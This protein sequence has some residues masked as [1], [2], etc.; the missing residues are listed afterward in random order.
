MQSIQSVVDVFFRNR[1]FPALLLLGFASGLPLFLTSR[2]L[3]IWMADAKVD[4][5]VIGWFSVVALPYSLK[6][7]WSPVMDRF[8]P[9]FL[10]R[11]RGWLLMTQVALILAI[12]VMAFQEPSSTNPQA[13]Q[14]L[15][16]TALAVTFFSASQDIAGDAYRTD[17]LEV[18]ERE[19]GASL[20]VLGYRLALLVTS[21]LALVLVDWFSALNIAAPWRWVYLLMAGLMGIGLVTTIWA[22]E[23]TDNTSQRPTAPLTLQDGLF[24]LLG[25]GVIAGIVELAILGF[26]LWIPWIVLGVLVLWVVVS[27]LMPQINLED[28][29]DRHLPQT[30]QEAVFQPFQ[31]FVQRRGVFSASM[32]LAFIVLYKLGDSLVG[33]MA[34]PFLVTLGFSKSSIGVI[35]GG[36]GFLATTSGVFLGGIILTQVGMNRALWIFGAL[37]LLSNFGYYALALA[38]KNEQLMVIAINIENLCAGFVTVVVVAYLMS[39]CDKRFTTT[40][41]A[42]FSSLMAISR[43]ILAAPAG[44]LAKATGWPAFFLITIAAAVPGLL[45]LP[46]IAP[47][48]KKPPVMPR[49]GLNLEV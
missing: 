19:A 1:K 5:G 25:I 26:A 41:F 43:D 29:G 45:M 4:L 31:E 38:G 6:F 10:G 35:Q 27:V 23:P 13:I 21:F 15:A 3:Q 47:W 2:T 30:L 28:L 16:F 9:P 44:N 36:M 33:N 42:L 49:P 34:N 14:I 46:Y 32:V 22:A 39:L 37:Q 24:L 48:N 18:P 20:W 7:V 17:V 11:R 40:Q 8:V 12:A